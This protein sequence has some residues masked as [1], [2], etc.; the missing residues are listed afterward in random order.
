MKNYIVI[1]KEPQPEAHMRNSV[2]KKVLVSFASAPIFTAFY[3]L[4]VQK[5]PLPDYMSL[6]TCKYAL[7]KYAN[8][9]DYEIIEYIKAKIE[10]DA[11]DYDNQ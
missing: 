8:P 11:Y 10:F 9:K 7:K 3:W 6:E 1:S 2:G 5:H 4:K